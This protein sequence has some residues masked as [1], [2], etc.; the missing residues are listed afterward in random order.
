MLP[1][2]SVDLTDISQDELEL[3]WDSLESFQLGGG[4]FAN[5]YHVFYRGFDA[6]LRRP[7]NVAYP[8]HYTEEV[9]EKVRREA[10]I[11]AALN[12]CENVVRLYGICDSFPFCGMIMEYCAGPNLSELVYKL[13]ESRVDLEMI[14]IFKWCREL[15][16]TLCELNRTHFHGDVKAENV[17]VKERPCCCREGDY[18]DVLVRNTT[19]KLC[20][21]CKGVHL[22]HLSLKLC[23]F[24]MSNEHPSKRVCFEGT[25]D[26]SAPETYDGTYTEKSEVYSF[27]HLML[28]LII[29]KPTEEC[30]DG[31]KRFLELYNNK[32]YDL[33]ECTSN[34]ICETITWCLDKTPEKRPTFKQLLE[35]I[36]S[37]FNHYKS[38]RGDTDRRSAANIEREEFLEHY[39]IPRKITMADRTG[40]TSTFLSISTDLSNSESDIPSKIF[41]GGPIDNAVFVDNEGGSPLSSPST[42]SKYDGDGMELSRNF[43][44]NHMYTGDEEKMIMLMPARRK[45][46]V[47]RRNSVLRFL[48]QAKNRISE[49]II[50]FVRQ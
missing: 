24:G 50:K 35:K 46:S 36:N 49:K 29:G 44:E 3:K 37:R 17:L 9:R 21:K 6:V 47:F 22:E 26:F 12:N 33:S 38:I 23:D 5:V 32:K 41:Y 4:G 15:A 20:K 19:Y 10:R 25:K 1:L 16:I 27:G 13:C 11:V 48:V 18:E 34:S 28:V 42:S 40:T 7:I 2:S 39:K 30:V 45:Q 8:M 14:R 31:Q 43:V